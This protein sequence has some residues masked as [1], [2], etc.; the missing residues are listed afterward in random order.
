MTCFYAVWGDGNFLPEFECF[1]PPNYLTK[2]WSQIFEVFPDGFCPG[3]PENR[4]P[5]NSNG[6][7]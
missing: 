6:L 7:W 2:K 1:F 3:L 5:T 4:L